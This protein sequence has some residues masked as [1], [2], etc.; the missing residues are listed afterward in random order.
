MRVGA[1]K[2]EEDEMV[3]W[4]HRLNGHE[5]EQIL[6]DSGGQRSPVCCGPW[7][8]KEADTNRQL[9]SSNSLTLSHKPCFF[10]LFFVLYVLKTYNPKR[11]VPNFTNSVEELQ[12]FF[13]CLSV[14][15]RSLFSNILHL[16]TFLKLKPI[17]DF[18]SVCPLIEKDKR[19]MKAS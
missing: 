16:V 5:F 10:I 2:S 4:H 14:C 13:F 17:T 7:G 6:G 15:K 12:D 18:Q 11:V 9:N 3:G 1:E 19:L 8:R